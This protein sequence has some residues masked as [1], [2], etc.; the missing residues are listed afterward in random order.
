[1]NKLKSNNLWKHLQ[2]VTLFFILASFVIAVLLLM[3]FNFKAGALGYS[4]FIEFKNANG[5]R[6]GTSL[7]MRG[8]NIGH[9]KKIKMG[10]NSVLVLVNIQSRYTFIPLNSVV[11]TNQTGLL[12]DTVIDVIPLE[13]LSRLAIKHINVVSTDCY[14]SSVVCHLNY[15]H[16]DRGLNYDDLIRAATRVS[17]RFD[18]PSFFNTMYFCFDNIF[19]LSDEFFNVVLDMSNFLSLFYHMLKAFLSSYK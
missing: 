6:E 12:N 1:M 9:V 7:R 15:L 14:Q 17:Q 4:I 3:K 11:E 13:T 10:L 19:E 5:I 2:S 18:D 16:G 8:V